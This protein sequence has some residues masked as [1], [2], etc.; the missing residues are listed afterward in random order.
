M[1]LSCGTIKRDCRPS[2]TGLL[3]DYDSG[4]SRPASLEETEDLLECLEILDCEAS[5]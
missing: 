4:E 2:V 5:L 3:L 1:K